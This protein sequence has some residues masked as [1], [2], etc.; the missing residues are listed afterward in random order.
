[1]KKSRAFSIIEL[2]II[3]MMISIISIQDTSSYKIVRNMRILSAQNVTRSS[4]VLSLRGLV[5]WY[6]TSLESS[7]SESEKNHNKPVSIWADNNPHSSFKNNIIQL[8]KNNF[9]PRYIE[10]SINGLP[11]LR[12]DGLDDFMR[13]SSLKISNDTLTIFLVGK[14]NSYSHYQGVM[15][16]VNSSTN[17]DMQNGS[18]VAFFDKNNFSTIAS[19]QSF[20]STTHPG[21]N[22]PY[23][24]STV[25]NGKKNVSYINGSI[26]VNVKG[27]IQFNIDKF[28]IGARVTNGKPT[29]YFS[30]DIAE[31]IIYNR[32]LANDERKSIEEYLSRKY[33]IKIDRY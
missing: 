2:S 27:S 6:E 14:R 25:F 5:G 15:S 23:I 10:N 3:T 4:P 31:I 7:I 8:D 21:N 20:S 13:I 19:G 26:G 28:F 18:L 9:K 12:F 30:G 1:M 11:A 33:S 17:D 32:T 22:T 16:G 29:N 24:V